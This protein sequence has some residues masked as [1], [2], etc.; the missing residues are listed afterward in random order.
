MRFTPLSEEGEFT[1]PPGSFDVRG[2]EVR[3]MTDGEKVGEVDD[4]L[5][6]DAGTIQ[7]LDVDLGTLRKHV[8]VPATRTRVDEAEG[9]VWVPGMS[10]SQFEGVPGYDHD[11]GTLT[12]DYRDRLDTAYAATW[13]VAGEPRREAQVRHF[14]PAGPAPTG[15]RGVREGETEIVEPVSSGPLLALSDFGQYEVAPGNPDP[16][17][18]EVISGDQRRVGMV[19]D[20]L[21][22]PTVMKVRYLDCEVTMPEFGEPSGGRHIL[23]PINYV[24]L[25]VG[26]RI[27]Y[28]DLLTAEAI[29]ELPSFPGLPLAPETEKR[30]FE[31]FSRGARRG[32]RYREGSFRHDRYREGGIHEGGIHEGE[33]RA[34]EDREDRY[35]A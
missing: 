13:P 19:H 22:A 20:L 25:D 29:S 26:E 16:R 27:V 15:E 23:L 4:L 3:A 34:D 2:W 9:V 17:G 33:Y 1:F 24:R 21:I 8:L 31:V 5:I 10:R 11:P 14:E 18:W 30:I 6:D 12:D 32:D 35:R 7:Y 28:V